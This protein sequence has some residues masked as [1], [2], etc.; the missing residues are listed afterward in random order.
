MHK[1]FDNKYEVWKN[2]YGQE[3]DYQIEGYIFSEY[4]NPIFRFCNTAKNEKY[5]NDIEKE[6][7]YFTNLARSN[8]SLFRSTF[9]KAAE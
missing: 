7:F 3:L 9:L 1:T 4:N 8:P 2:W 5:L 6:L